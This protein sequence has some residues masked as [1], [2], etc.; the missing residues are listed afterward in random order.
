[1][2]NESK[3][4]QITAITA[5]SLCI[6]QKL[7]FFFFL[8]FAFIRF[9]GLGDHFKWMKLDHALKEAEKS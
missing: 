1:M 6:A 4:A 8:I 9:L 5:T 3:S 2:E 7:L